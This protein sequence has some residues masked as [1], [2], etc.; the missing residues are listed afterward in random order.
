MSVNRMEDQGGSAMRTCTLVLLTIVAAVSACAHTSYVGL[1][2][3]GACR[4]LNERTA[5]RRATV[6]LISGAGFQAQGVLVTP[7]S[8]SWLDPR[9]DDLRT[10]P[11][12]QVLELQLVS[13]GK[14]ALQGFGIGVLSGA[15]TGAFLGIADGDDPRSDGFNI[16]RFS[17][18]QKAA[19]GAVVLGGLGG[20]AGLPLGASVGSR[21]IYR[22]EASHPGKPWLRNER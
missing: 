4:R 10:V 20:L 18:A 2:D 3:A 17:A 1:P 12:E 19:M 14:G 15:V 8:T 5:G 9:T 21:D 6:I 13:H 16:M 22:F 7:D 11:T